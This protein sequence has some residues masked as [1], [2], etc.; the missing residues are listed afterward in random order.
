MQNVCDIAVYGTHICVPHTFKIFV[1][2]ELQD[3]S[4]IIESEERA[5]GRW[6]S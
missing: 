1:R 4:I 5:G 2:V 3:I 6:D